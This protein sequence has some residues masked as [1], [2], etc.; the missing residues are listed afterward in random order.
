MLS[1]N[2]YGMIALVQVLLIIL[3]VFVDSGLG[4]ALIQKKEVDTL[5]YSSVFLLNVVFS[6]LLYIVVWMISPWLAVFYGIPEITMLIRVLSLIFLFGALR[7][8]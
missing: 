3:G 6:F 5:D 1:Q 4:S 8:V 7:N 2:D